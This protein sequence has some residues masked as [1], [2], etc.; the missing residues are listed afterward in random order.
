MTFS[1]K[2]PVLLILLCAATQAQAFTFTFPFPGSSGRGDQGQPPGPPPGWQFRPQEPSNARGVPPGY[3]PQGQIPGQAPAQITSQMPGPMRGPGLQPGAPGGYQPVWPGQYGSSPYGRQQTRQMARPPRLELEVANRQPYLQENVL[4]KLRVIS[5]Q[6]LLTATP[7]LPNSNDLL[8]QRLDGPNASTRVGEGGKREIV[9][10]FIYTLT[11]LRAGDLELPP[12][13]VRGEMSGGYAYG[14]GSGSQYEGTTREK[15]LLEVRPAMTSVQPWLPL[16]DLDL[17]ATLDGGEEVEEGQPVTL[18][19]ELAATGATGSQLPSLEGYLQS[20]DFRVYREQTLTEGKLS[21]DGRRLL[22]KRTE[23]YTLVPH[24][25]GKLHLPEIRLPWWN[26]NNGTRE[27]AS[28][29]IQMLQ[30]EG[31]SGPFGFPVSGGARGGGGLSWF[32]LP[33]LGLLLL[34]L[35]YWIG[36][37]FQGQAAKRPDRESLTSRFAGGLRS[38][39]AKASTSVVGAVGKLN[40]APVLNSVGPA[41]AKALP[42]SSRFLGCVRAANRENEPAAWAERFQ[43]TTCRRV[44]FDTQTSLPGISGQILKLRPNADRERIERLMRQLD[45]AL[46]GNQDIDF[47]RW[48]KQFS[49]E[50]GRSRGLFNRRARGPRFRRP[51]LPALNPQ[52]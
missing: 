15:V 25:G 5:D 52:T 45:G 42:P 49:R 7:D 4:L 22:G 36:V 8:F 10:E 44:H 47:R 50:V 33:L 14:R 20:A 30:V 6:N 3:Q 38:A 24:S 48:K 1:A 51:M 13:R 29:P 12:L 2:G 37:W 40:P 21:A 46:Y 16:Q 19:L 34:V 32:W 41:L 9:N 35:G 26:V 28:L 27:Y 39:G 18:A 43:E 11:P 17:N 23:Y 31:E